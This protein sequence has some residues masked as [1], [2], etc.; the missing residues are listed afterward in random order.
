MTATIAQLIAAVLC[1]APP[2]GRDCIPP[3]PPV[4]VIQ[5]LVAAHRRKR[6]R[7]LKGNIP[8]S[9]RLNETPQPRHHRTEQRECR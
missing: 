2:L 6:K 5:I 4:R 1:L 3:P 9:G 7:R 8:R